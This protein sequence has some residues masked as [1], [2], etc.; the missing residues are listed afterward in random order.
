[1]PSIHKSAIVED[2][3]VIKKGAKIGA[4]T[5]ISSKA[6]IGENVQVMQGAQVCNKTTIGKNTK[7]F[8]YAMVGANPQD[9]KY[10]DGQ[11]TALEVGENSIIREFVT[12]NT[13]TIGGGGL[14]RVG[15]NVLIMNYCHIAH[16]CILGDNAILANNATLAGHVEVGDFVVIGGLTPIHQFV[17]I[18]EGCMVAG[19]SALNQDLPPFCL[20]EGNRAMIKSL[21]L[22]GLRRRF[23]KEDINELKTAFNSLFRSKKPLRENAQNIFET[24]QN[25][26][27]KKMCEFILNTK[28][29]I[30]YERKV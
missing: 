16:D 8:P 25:E 22:T 29:G 6:T 5:F 19:A 2:G 7:V 17:K 14:T 20:A 13:G 30:P 12:I 3:A 9:L 1:M 24:S 23:D 21:N 15:S 4:Y 18:G 11:D 10:K 26:K 27:V 28:R